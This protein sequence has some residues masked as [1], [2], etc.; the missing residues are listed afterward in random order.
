MALE[1]WE[2]GRGREVPTQVRVCAVGLDEQRQPMVLE[3]Y[4]RKAGGKRKGKRE[5]E[6]PAMAMW[7]EEGKGGRKGELEM[8]VRKVR[9]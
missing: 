6:R 4:Y 1:I 5:R 7:K 3:H 2:E 9:A 8:R